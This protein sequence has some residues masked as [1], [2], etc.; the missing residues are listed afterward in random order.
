MC[1]LVGI[2]GDT[3]GDWKDVFTEL[4]VVDSFRGMHST[5]M[6][7][8][9]R[10]Q[11]EINLL[12][13][14][15]PTHFLLQEPDYKTY[16]GYPTKALIGHN[17]HAT[18]GAH[19]IDNAHPFQFSNI[20]GA[21]NGTLEKHSTKRLYQHDQFGTD[22]EAIFSH[23]NQFGVEATIENLEGAWALT[24]F[25]KEEN[26]INFL[27]NDRRPLY[28]TYSKSRET[29]LWASEES[30]L[31]YVLSRHK[32][33]ET[34]KDGKIVHPFYVADADHHLYWK[35]PEFITGKFDAPEKV[36]RKGHP[37]TPISYG[38]YYGGWKPHEHRSHKKGGTIKV[39][40]S[41]ASGRVWDSQLQGYVDIDDV[42]T[43]NVV[44]FRTGG[45]KSTASK[46][47]FDT[48]RDTKKFRPPYKD[49]TGKVMNK[50][51]FFKFVADGCIMCNNN[52]IDWGDFIHPFKDQD[53]HHVF[54]CEDCYND[55]DIQQTCGYLL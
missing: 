50:K 28:Y 17:R 41:Y 5:G 8:V 40:H 30:M 53:G 55:P 34:D 45:T 16:L 15:G 22:S 36:E 13:R 21:H 1:G 37:I 4:L 31:R 46:R 39:Y 42:G 47:T 26:T 52:A 48:K 20:V 27:R 38:G 9:R 43:D 23:M 14:V 54:L 25:N 44:P 3:G 51:A 6:A 2:A 32:K 18:I 24:W 11:S 35:I 12:K 10:F 49:P 7:A 33:L 19:T 29:L